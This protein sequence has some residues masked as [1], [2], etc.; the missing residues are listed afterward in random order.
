MPYIILLLSFIVF[1]AGILIKRQ[2]NVGPDV[3]EELPKHVYYIKKT[4]N[5]ILLLMYIF[6]GI[7]FRFRLCVPALTFGGIGVIL[8]VWLI[9]KSYSLG[10]KETRG[11]GLLNL[12]LISSM[13]AV[14]FST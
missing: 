10:S 13:I 2:Y 4:T 7:S 8:C 5:G 12:L 6:V 1:V 3:D 9:V 14:I 11:D